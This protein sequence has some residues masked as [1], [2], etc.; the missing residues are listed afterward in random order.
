M[1]YGS[2]IR[3]FRKERGLTLSQLAEKADISP[4]YLSGIERG[5][6]KAS[7]NV[8]NKLSGAVNIPVSYLVGENIP[9]VQDDGYRIHLIRNARG[10]TVEELAEISD[11]PSNVITGFEEGSRKLSLPDMEKLCDALNVDVSYLLSRGKKKYKLSERLRSIREAQGMTVTLLADKAGVSPGFISQLENNLTMP[12]FESLEAIARAMGIASSYIWIE[13]E[14]LEELLARLS[15][16]V[17]ELLSDTNVQTVLRMISDFDGSEL[18]Y[19]L[20]YIEFFKRHRN[21]LR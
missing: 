18:K 19:L 12:S 2:K 11:L 3:E 20:K 6:K 14:D 15:P 7:L 16:D 8:L 4:S 9:G 13:K 5:V 17:L 21:L 10:L 1:S